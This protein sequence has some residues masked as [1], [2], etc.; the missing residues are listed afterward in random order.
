ML[1]IILTI[2]AV[3]TS[4]QVLAIPKQIDVIGLIPDV[5]TENDFKN[6]EK[7]PYEVT[8]IVG[9]HEMIC[10]PTYIDSNLSQLY[11]S[12]GNRSVDPSSNQAI[13]ATLKKG[14]T[15]KFGVPK[16]TDSVTSNLMGTKFQ[17]QTLLWKDQK[18]NELSIMNRF[19]K[20]DEG[21]LLLRSVKQIK[22]DKESSKTEEQSR[23]F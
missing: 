18:G 8:T 15:Q 23:K 9:G 13:Y 4:S 7:G 17:K 20:V 14:F 3:F 1:K 22:A 10:I 6:A 5:A 2:V 21:L 12:F 16:T 19:A 11:C